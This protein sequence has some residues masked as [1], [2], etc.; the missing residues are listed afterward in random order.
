M[1][2]IVGCPIASAKLPIRL[3]RNT[4]NLFSKLAAQIIPDDR[5]AI[6]SLEQPVQDFLTVQA[7][8][9]SLRST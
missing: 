6:Q 4:Y 7:Q 9:A 5:T 3:Q 2:Q 1:S 8:A